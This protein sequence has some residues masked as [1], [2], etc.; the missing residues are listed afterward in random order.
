[1][2]ASKDY[3]KTLNQFQSYLLTILKV[4][5]DLVPILRS[6]LTSIQKD[7]IETLNDCLRSQQALMLQ[8]KNFDAKVVEYQTMLNIKAANLSELIL[9]L[10]NEDQMP[11]FE[12]L[13]QFGQ[14]SD[15][16]RFYQDKCKTLL[17]SKLYLIDKVLS[18]AHM[19]KDNVTYNKDAAEVQRSLFSKSL[20]VKI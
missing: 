16:V 3:D 2:S 18:K 17:Q 8:T 13:S 5:Q 20:E 15:E 12:I 9:K 4:Y 11:F 10:P 7:D 19:P 6:E 14:T 1:M